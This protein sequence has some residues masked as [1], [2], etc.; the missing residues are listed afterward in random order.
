MAVVALRPNAPVTQQ[1]Q[2][3]FTEE[4]QDLVVPLTAGFGLLTLACPVL[5]LLDHFNHLPKLG[6]A[7]DV[8]L[9]AIMSTDGTGHDFPAP[10]PTEVIDTRVTEVVS[11]FCGV[12]F[13]QNIQTDVALGLSLESGHVKCP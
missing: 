5:E 10:A 4:G 9:L 12:W 1:L 8:L 3:I 7:C 6:I 11:T 13:G 2:V